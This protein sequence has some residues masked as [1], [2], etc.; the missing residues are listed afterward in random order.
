MVKVLSNDDMYFSRTASPEE[1]FFSLEKSM[2]ASISEEMIKMVSTIKDFSNLVGEPVEKYRPRYENLA[3]LRKEFFLNIGNDPDIE[4]FL[5]YY[6]WIDDSITEIIKQ[7]IPMSADLVESNANIV[8]S[9]ILERNKYQHQY[10]ALEERMPSIS[11]PAK[12]A[13]DMKYAW[14][15]GHAPVS[16]LHS[17]NCQWWNQ[18]AEKTTPAMNNSNPVPSDSLFDSMRNTYKKE[19]DKAAVL[20]TD[21]LKTHSGHSNRVDYAVKETTFGSGDYLLIESSDVVSDN[22]DCEREI[23]PDKKIKFGFAVKKTS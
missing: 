12:G 15:R 13:G 3:M 10:P 20:I 1:Y 17:Q 21:N 4:N 2:Y 7:F 14:S 5:E 23:T 8:E 9:H 18:R 22:I 11:S 19:R 16:Q 6:K